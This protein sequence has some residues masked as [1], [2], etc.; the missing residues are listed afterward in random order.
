MIRTLRFALRMF[1]RDFGSGELAVLIAALTTA[2]GSVT[3][4]GFLTDRVGQAVLAQAAEALAADLRVR[5][6]ER[7]AASNLDV[8]AARGLRTATT[9]TFP[10]VTFAG[11]ASALATVKAVSVTYPLRGHVR[12]SE[13]LFAAE[14]R[15]D[16]VPEAGEAWPDAGLAA[17]LG[18]DAG[19]TIELGALTLDVTR[20]LTF[21][22]DQSGGFASLAPSL[23]IN[24][25]DIEPSGLIGEGSRVSHAQLFAG[26][27]E[28]I[29]SFTAELEGGLPESLSIETRGESNENLESAID[30]SRRFLA[31]ASLVSLLLAAVAVA[32]SARRFAERRLDTAALMKSLG[33]RQDFVLWTHVIELVLVAI[34]ASALG[35]AVGFAAERGLTLA[36][37][38]L[39]PNDLPSPSAA[40][41][42]IGFGTAL[43]LLLGFAVP[44]L[45]R[46]R[47]TPPLRVLRHDMEPPPPSAWLS[48]GAALAALG[49][50]VFWS[51]R[52]AQLVGIIL[53][54]TAIAGVVLYLAG[55]A[56]V[57]LLAKTRA[58]VGV[59]W[60]YGLANV[61]RRGAASAVQ[62]VAFGLGL[63][64][65]LFLTLVRNDLMAA[66]RSNIGDGVPNQFLINIQPEERESVARILESGGLETPEFV[67]LIRARM[68]R[69]N[70]VDVADVEYPTEGGER[71]AS[72]E[73]NLSFA[74]TLSGSNDIDSGEF[75]DADYRGDPLVSVD[76]E[77][78][79]ELGLDLGDVL[80]FTIAG[81]RLDATVTSTRIIDWESFEPNFF[82][83][84]SPG[85]L[86]D[87]PKTYIASMHVAAEHRPTLLTLVR[88]HPSVSVIDI[89]AILDQVRTVI[90]RATT[91]VQA[92]FVFTLVA[93]LVVLF[94]AVGATIDERRYESALLRTF[95]ARSTT[96]YAGIATEFIALGLCAGFFAALGATILGYVTAEQLFDLGYTF[97]PLLWFSGFAGGAVL[98]GLSGMFA[99][100]SAVRTSP[101]TTLRQR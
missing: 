12:T 92:V 7:P 19:D 89:G 28:D 13:R 40:P 6:P 49:L 87:Y 48:Y 88:K 43:I 25:A 22:P 37:G 18:I 45:L 47:A 8:A 91:A 63:M 82:M 96:V 55:R 15:T 35:S 83:V 75:W 16:R 86:D 4:I 62:I 31:L 67:P 73:A 42:A 32:M 78:A 11:D 44:S 14:T 97:D 60:R 85:A 77:V 69:I 71:F 101:L 59:A 66:W 10:S 52:D 74:S 72:R 9:M 20:I 38:D 56:L 21:R 26:P 100:R 79:L 65:L 34:V 93:G 80:S 68:T 76:D 54:G 5:G 51:V 95:G 17:R 53:G 50:M 84:F 58:R 90:Q 30:R 36:L 23:L 64:V 98:V 27:A 99:S 39:V 46:L 57:G 24:I 81:E 29:S 70:D 3:A 1:A 61:S 94:A 2:V 41:V 33:A